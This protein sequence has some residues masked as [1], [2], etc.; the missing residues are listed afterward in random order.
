M[1]S[2]DV[3]TQ[4]NI[5]KPDEREDEKVPDPVVAASNGRVVRTTAKSDDTTDYILYYGSG[6]DEADAFSI[7]VHPSNSLRLKT[8]IERNN[9]VAQ[10]QDVPPD[11]QVK[12]TAPPA[13]VGPVELDR[14]A[15]VEPSNEAAKHHSQD[16]HNK[17]HME[18]NKVTSRNRRH[19]ASACN[20]DPFFAER[21]QTS[22]GETHVI[23]S[24]E[25]GVS[26]DG[27]LLEPI[28]S[29]EARVQLIVGSC[30]DTL[31]DALSE[32]HHD[33]EETDNKPSTDDS[34]VDSWESFAS[35]WLATEMAA[36]F[37]EDDILQDFQLGA[38]A[39]ALLD[40][41][42]VVELPPAPLEDPVSNPDWV[43]E[44]PPEC[45]ATTIASASLGAMDS[46]QDFLSAR[47]TDGDNVGMTDNSRLIVEG[48]WVDPATK[49]LHVGRVGEEVRV[50][51]S[52][53]IKCNFLP[54]DGSFFA[55]K[56]QHNKTTPTV[57]LDD[58]PAAKTYDL[59]GLARQNLM[60]T[61][62]ITMKAKADRHDQ[63]DKHYQHDKQ[64]KPEA[65]ST[66]VAV[67]RDMVC[68]S[69]IPILR[70][71]ASE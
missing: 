11:L 70:Y 18:D 4:R 13:S 23:E 26:D 51:S 43:L 71:K 38:D 60:M 47:N 31:Q 20:D 46:N 53:D 24:I 1:V 58:E 22:D 32:F 28:W 41:H 56:E 35:E 59:S 19:D 8:S 25:F 65:S 67:M 39:S 50:A 36:S 21:I 52:P 63:H 17:N 15:V 54:E 45:T 10:V 34:S 9:S 44:G 48:E 29:D 27:F 66:G 2:D 55:T 16:K 64:D 61:T 69:F 7:Q 49:N 6:V 33:T 57:R 12:T 5:E 14:N 40:P 68:P 62:T 37:A 30:E 42:R 3:V